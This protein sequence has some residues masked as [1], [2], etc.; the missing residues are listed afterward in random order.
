MV[1]NG[2]V[3]TKQDR[4]GARWRTLG[5]L[6]A[7]LLTVAAAVLVLLYAVPEL[8]LVN[9]RLAMVASFIPYG[10]IA[11]AVAG[12]LFAISA[13]GWKKL[14][15]LLVLPGLV[16]QASWASGYLPSAS[17]GQVG[18]AVFTLNSRCE[19][20][21]KEHLAEILLSRQPDLVVLQ[22][23][24]RNLRRHL[25]ES[26]LGDVYPHQEFF[27]MLDPS[28]CGTVVYSRTPLVETSWATPEQPVSRV[29]LGDTEVVLLPAD[30]PGPQNGVPAWRA[31][32][33]RIGQI[34][35]AAAAEG[36]PVVAAGDFNA[37]REHL[38]I[39]QLTGPGGLVDATESAGSGW[40]PSYRVVG[41]F[42]P[43]IQIDHVFVTP[44]ID[45]GAVR[46]LQVSR[47]A[48]L[49]VIAWLDL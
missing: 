14:L 42:V 9:R 16:V 32:I 31:A 40:L 19:S 3:G 35:T 37:V 39:S 21:G 23:T 28:W 43:L 24:D 47:H 33:E 17:R 48:H 11:W 8:Q 18:A 30:I 22:G 27:P 25:A 29:V 41:W 26:G 1:D 44:G 49:A 10:I 2:L 45:V 36:W 6:A 7:W 46:T 20:V 15:A 13:R 5:L 12:V 38:P 34:S 4:P